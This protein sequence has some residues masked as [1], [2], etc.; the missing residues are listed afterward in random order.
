MA[1]NLTSKRIGEWYARQ[2][3]TD[4]RRSTD[5]RHDDQRPYGGVGG[6]AELFPI[7]IIAVFISG[8]MVGRTPGIHGT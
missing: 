3:D 1:T 2:S 7:F 4:L 8:L 5:A 6:P